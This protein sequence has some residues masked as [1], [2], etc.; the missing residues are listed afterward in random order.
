MNAHL[1]IIPCTKNKIWDFIPQIGEVPAVCA[2]IGPEFILS[3]YFLSSRSDRMIIFS[4][5]YGFLDLWDKIPQTYDVTF[6][7]PDDHFIDADSL[8]LQAKR[9]GLLNFKYITTTCN[10][11]YQKRIV[12]TFA[13]SGIV[14][15]SPVKG[16]ESDEQIC[17]IINKL[18]SQEIDIPL[19]GTIK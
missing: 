18:I 3:R 2:Y 14:I 10:H 16:L 9:K 19:Y 15:N 7:R 11:Y 12:E 4:A 17:Q 1:S 5:K 6:A 13:P 8:K